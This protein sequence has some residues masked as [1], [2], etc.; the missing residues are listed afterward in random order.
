MAD[1]GLPRH[2]EHLPVSTLFRGLVPGRHRCIFAAEGHQTAIV[3]VD[4]PAQGMAEIE[5]KLPKR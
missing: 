2:D 1:P 4:V 3:N 5:V